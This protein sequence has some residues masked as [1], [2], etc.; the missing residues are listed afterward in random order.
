MMKRV[1]RTITAVCYVFGKF[2]RNF[3]SLVEQS[4]VVTIQFDGRQTALEPAARPNLTG[5]GRQQSTWHAA[6][7]QLVADVKVDGMARI[8]D[9]TSRQISKQAK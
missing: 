4:P 9:V 8:D 7:V 3:C 6:D 2:V 5:H 1:E